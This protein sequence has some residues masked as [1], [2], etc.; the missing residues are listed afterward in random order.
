MV[1]PLLAL[2]AVLLFWSVLIGASWH[3]LPL[4][5]AVASAAV[6]ALGLVLT[7]TPLI[8]LFLDQTRTRSPLPGVEASRFTLPGSGYTFAA[9]GNDAGHRNTPQVRV[10][11]GGGD[12]HFSR[13]ATEMSEHQALEEAGFTVVS[14]SAPWRGE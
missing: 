7:A 12:R 10:P 9:S 11:G 14:L 13:E 3:F 1:K 8:N 2:S 5:L 4:P 6:D